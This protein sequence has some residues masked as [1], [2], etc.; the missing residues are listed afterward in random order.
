VSH[1]KYRTPANSAPVPETWEPLQL[2]TTHPGGSEQWENAL[3]VVH[4]TIGASD[5]HPDWKVFHLSIRRQDRSA[6][7]DWRHKQ[8]IKNQLVGP[9]EEAVE[10]YP[11]ES[12]LVDGANQFHL[13]GLLGH[14][15]P[16]GFNEREVAEMDG[17]GKAKQRPFDIKPPDLNIVDGVKLDALTEQ[18]KRTGVIPEGASD[19][20]TNRDKGSGG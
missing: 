16:F 20:I 5:R 17:T 2:A 12:R 1:R 9:E 4:K 13:W 18:Y 6:T 14:S 11:A 15:I 7:T 8:Y 19:Y 10:I 3:Y